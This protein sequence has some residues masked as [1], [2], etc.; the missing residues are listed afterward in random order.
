MKNILAIIS[1]ASLAMLL[2]VPGCTEDSTA[3]PQGFG[4]SSATATVAPSGDVIITISGGTTPY[5]ITAGTDTV[6]ATASLSGGTLTVSGVDGGF[7]TV[8]VGDAAA[9][10]VTI[11]IVCRARSPTTLLV[12]GHKYTFAGRDQHFRG[13]ARSH[14]PVPDHLTGPAGPPRLHRHRR[15]T[16]LIHP[17]RRD[18]TARNLLT[19]SNITG[20]FFSVQSSTFFCVNIE[21]TDTVQSFIASLNPASAV[22]GSRSIPPTSTAF[23]ISASA[24]KSRHGRGRQ[25]ITTA[26]RPR[27]KH[28]TIGSAPRRISATGAVIVDNATTS[29]PG[30]SGS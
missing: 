27:F 7:T 11:S 28:E 13:H 30:S 5:S 6:V 3:P 18:P 21:R 23:G 25:V 1:F 8:T 20:E 17:P 29:R 10:S 4:V 22:N 2:F 9:A 15:S 12:A 16:R 26:H 19:K 24:P 14:E